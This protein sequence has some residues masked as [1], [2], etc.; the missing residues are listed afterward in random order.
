MPSSTRRKNKGHVYY[1]NTNGHLQ[2]KRLNVATSIRKCLQ[3]IHSKLRLKVEQVAGSLI[4]T[5][6]IP[7]NEIC[8]RQVVFNLPVQKVL[9]ICTSF[10]T[11]GNAQLAPISSYAPT[12]TLAVALLKGLDGFMF[13]VSCILIQLCN[14]NQQMHILFFKSMF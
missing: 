8:S 9:K 14:V 10:K 13:C 2:G 4:T 5:K 6:I 11:Q 12:E 1:L 7:G 3:Q